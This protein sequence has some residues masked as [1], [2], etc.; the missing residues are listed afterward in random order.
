MRHGSRCPGAL[1]DRG[2]RRPDAVRG[3]GAGSRRRPAT[4]QGGGARGRRHG[5]P[6]D[7]SAQGCR[8]PRPLWE[9]E[10]GVAADL[11]L[12]HE[13]AA[14]PAQFGDLEHGAAAD[15]PLEREAAV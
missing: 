11:P 8:H 7:L 12:V 3:A 1:R 15:L 5:I 4:F 10:H 14:V 6:R 13:A 2:R 9:L